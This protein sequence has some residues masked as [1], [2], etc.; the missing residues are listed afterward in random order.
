MNAKDLE[1]EARRLFESYRSAGYSEGEALDLVQR[2]GLVRVAHPSARR[3]HNAWG[4]PLNAPEAKESGV[5]TS[6]GLG[7]TRA[8]Q[9]VE[10]TRQRVHPSRAGPGQRG[11]R[12][13]RGPRGRT[14]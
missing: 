8:A 3:T 6:D 4:R 14:G 7:K 2:S 1:G 5:P 13:D 9:S 12:P 11:L 10:F